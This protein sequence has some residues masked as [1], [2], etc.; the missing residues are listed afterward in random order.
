[1]GMEDYPANMMAFEKR[2]SS[3]QACLD[4]VVQLR[5]AGTMQCPHCGCE[6]LW[7]LTA[8]FECSQCGRQKRILSGTLFE[9]T[10]L[11][12]SVWFRAIWWVAVQKNG[13]SALGLQRLLGLSYK[14]T[15]AML[16]KIRSVMVDPQRKKLSGRVEVDE[17]YV[18][19]LDE[20]AMG[21]QTGSKAL[22]VIAAQE[23]GKGVGRVRLRV[24]SEA[25]SD[26]LLAFIKQNIEPGST[27]HT[28][29]W[30]GY[31]RV[32]KSGYQHQVTV[33]KEEGAQTMPRVHLVASLLKR[34]LLGTHQG[35]VSKV[36]LQAYLEEF[37][38][39]FNR[40][41]S[42]SRGKL[43]YR[44]IE[45]AVRTEPLPFEKITK[46]SRPF[47]HPNAHHS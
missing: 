22:V 24:I 19:G 45:R 31:A 39:R 37:V 16:H 15:W 46:H 23:H 32:G 30:Q 38:F 6:K 3:E 12:L 41:T 2:F 26:E 42:R 33:I 27:V 4:Y 47:R 13:A 1:M 9:G 11:P 5:W 8:G 35:G 17:T 36:H 20:E 10:H 18:G 21:R 44:I 29:A 28:D 43:F 34:W 40:R 25:S 14:T 7:R